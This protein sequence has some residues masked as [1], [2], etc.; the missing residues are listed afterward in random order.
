V[1]ERIRSRTR[2]HERR[3]KRRLARARKL[4]DSGKPVMSAR[5]PSYKV[6]ARVQAMG[7][8]GIGAAH[9]IAVQ[10][11]L[12]ERIDDTLELLKV[13]KPYHE[14]DHVLNI[15]YNALCGGR[16]L[17]DIELRR[18][19]EAFLD[20]LGVAAI[21]DPTTAGDFCR[22]FSPDDIEHLMGAVNQ[23]RQVVW[24]RQGA[25]FLGQT[26][27]IDA[28]GTF[29]GTGGE[30]KEGIGLSYKG[31][32]SYHPLLVSLANTA[33]PLFIVNRSG[34]RPSHEGAAEYMDRAAQLCLGAGFTDIMFRGD[35]DFSLTANFD[36]WDSLGYRFVFGY[37]AYKNLKARANGL[38]DAEY[39]RLV[40]RAEGAFEGKR[41]ARPPR[42]K[43][44]IVRIK[45]YKNI[46]LRSEDVAEFSY[47]P[48]KC[49]KNY[50]IIVLRKNLTIEKGEQ[51]LFDEIRY[52]F[53]VTND[54]DMS[55]ENVV[56]ESNERCNQ[57][58]LIA[59]LK[60]LR[61]LHAPV[62]TLD[63]N[64]AYMV[65]ASLAWTLKAWM[66]LWPPIDPR[67]RGKHIAERDNWLRMGFRTFCNRVVNTPA[68]VVSSGRRLV[69]RLLGWR[70][71]HLQLFRLLDGL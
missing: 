1:N 54:P 66:A 68:Q 40:R 32:W 47:K 26:A 38:E 11:G 30:C 4:K 46:K 29:V 60:D 13:H 59:Q 34:N 57:E 52:F 23:T 12:V 41:R 71:D 58:K 5:R 37:D 36:R 15:G 20:A 69:I 27:R 49:K 9:Q 33:E 56:R 8:G 53:Y 3:I 61:A 6:A 2:G 7:Y 17:D 51:A 65:M 25:E 24:A 22:R 18:N 62:N 48:T 67:W 63:A 39:C 55:V 35:T 43:E 44:Q 19:D 42:F 28:D 14:S 45:G 64:W 21:P 31:G 10:S 50:R 70:P 16:T